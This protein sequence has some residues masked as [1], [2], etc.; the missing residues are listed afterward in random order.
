MTTRMD[1]IDGS[2][3]RARL[4]ARHGSQK[5]L[6]DAIGMPPDQLT[7]IMK[8]GRQVKAHEIPKILAYF[9]ENQQPGLREPQAAVH[10]RVGGEQDHRRARAPQRILRPRKGAAQ[11]RSGA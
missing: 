7:K 9:N 10:P 3:I 11:W 2:W 4:S 5:A 1:V 8:G 6:A